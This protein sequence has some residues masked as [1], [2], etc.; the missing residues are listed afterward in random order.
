MKPTVSVMIDLAAPAG[1]TA[2]RRERV[3]SVAKSLSSARTSAPVSALSSVL[4]P[5]LV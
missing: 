4:L 1:R 3:S 2:S 5:A